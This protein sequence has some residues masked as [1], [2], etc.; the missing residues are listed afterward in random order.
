M[1]SKTAN[2]RIGNTG[3]TVA[4]DWLHLPPEF[5]LGEVSDVAVD[6]RDRVYLFNRGPQ[7]VAIFDRDGNLLDHWGAGVFNRPHGIN[8]GPDDRV[9]HR[10]Q[11]LHSSRLH[12]RGKAGLDPG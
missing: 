3:F 6:G 1:S 7:P 8:I 12:P 10:R 4:H 2:S 11:G 9:L 5:E